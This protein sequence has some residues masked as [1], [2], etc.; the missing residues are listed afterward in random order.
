M[1]IHKTAIIGSQVEL[2]STVS[3]GAYSVITGRVFIKKNT[4]IHNNVSIG[5]EHGIVEIGEG[6]EIFQGAVLGGPPQ[7]INYDKEP[8]KLVLGDN[9][10][11]REFTTLNRGT[12]KTDIGTTQL[13]H[14]NLLM[15]YVHIAHDCVLEDRIAIANCSQLAGHVH[16]EN[17]VIVSGCCGMV[18]KV[19]LGRHSYIG[20]ASYINKDVLPFSIAQGNWAKMKATNKI[21]LKRDNFLIEEVQNI[22]KAIRLFL[23]GHR[24]VNDCIEEIQKQCEISQNV[25]AIIQFAENSQNGLAR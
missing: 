9:N 3:I 19:R 21:G 11:I 25:E 4:V 12:S 1:A 13:G 2:D 18:Q 23:T 15:A 5:S 14:N 8:T 10:I 6:N 7:D 24:T 22:H 20:G 16:I 17:D